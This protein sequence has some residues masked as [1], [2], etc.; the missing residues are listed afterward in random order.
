MGNDGKPLLA[1]VVILQVL[2]GGKTIP[3]DGMKILSDENKIPSDAMA[4]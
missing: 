2:K 1:A 4:I 3:S